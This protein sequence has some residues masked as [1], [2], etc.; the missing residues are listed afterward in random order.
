MAAQCIPLWLKA[1]DRAVELRIF[2][3]E[4]V[5]CHNCY[6]AISVVA[7][8]ISTQRKSKELFAYSGKEDILLLLLSFIRLLMKFLLGNLLC[9]KSHVNFNPL[10]YFQTFLFPSAFISL[11][12]FS[13]LS[14]PVS[15]V[16]VYSL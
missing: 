13:F 11:S 15:L 5:H 12:F 3:G 16:S 2:K 6:K 14:F 4:N 10:N 8:N 9:L 1:V 7:L